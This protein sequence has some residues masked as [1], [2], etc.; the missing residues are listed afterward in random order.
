MKR[1]SR[2]DLQEMKKNM[3]K[4]KH[5]AEKSKVY[6]QKEVEQMDQFLQQQWEQI[7]Q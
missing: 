6:H 7:E 3:K 2:K 1:L 5:V 4:V